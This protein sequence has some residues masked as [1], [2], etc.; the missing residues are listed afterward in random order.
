[1]RE[2]RI[3]LLNA[4]SVKPLRY[5]KHFIV[6]KATARELKAWSA[7]P[8][9]RDVVPHRV[10]PEIYS[11]LVCRD[12]RIGSQHEDEL[13]R[14]LMVWFATSSLYSATPVEAAFVETWDRRQSD[15]YDGGQPIELKIFPLSLPVGSA[16]PW[17]GPI[18]LERVQRAVI[19]ALDRFRSAHAYAG[20]FRFALSRWFQS[21]NKQRRT[22]EDAVVDLVIAL[23]AVFILENERGEKEE[24]LA[25]RISG[26]WFET[27]PQASTNRRKS[28][29]WKVRKAYKIRSCVVHGN[30]M[31]E[32]EL[33]WAR[34]FLDLVLRELLGDFIA[35]HLQ[36]FDPR[37]FWRTQ[38]HDSALFVIPA[39]LGDAPRSDPSIDVTTAD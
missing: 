13:D 5:R 31:E 24:F 26:F 35:G 36:A 28:F 12:P 11:V 3:P 23:E 27:E 33:E 10:L 38:G 7:N 4:R 22:L 2:W 15:R 1:M 25:E 39:S 8:F 6:R 34:T 17:H 18:P 16:R 29:R 14:D 20:A 19:D 21:L 9:V 30:I 32:T 37:T